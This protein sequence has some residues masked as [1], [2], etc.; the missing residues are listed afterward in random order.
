MIMQWNKNSMSNLC[1]LAILFLISSHSII[2]AQ[3]MVWTWFFAF[4][5]WFWLD[6]CPECFRLWMIFLSFT[7]SAHALHSELLQ[8]GTYFFYSFTARFFYWLS[9][10]ESIISKLELINFQLVFLFSRTNLKLAH[11]NTAEAKVKTKTNA[12]SK[13]LEISNC[14]F[15][16]FRTYDHRELRSVKRCFPPMTQN[17]YRSFSYTRSVCAIFT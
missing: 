14:I 8:H 4:W 16:L 2:W 17:L 5:F 13:W 6:F 10:R 1:V 12:K 11:L 9:I 7:W 15:K 3:R